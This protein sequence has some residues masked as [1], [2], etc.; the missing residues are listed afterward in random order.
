MRVIAA[1][2]A[3]APIDRG[4]ILPETDI[5]GLHAAIVGTLFGMDRTQVELARSLGCSTDTVSRHRVPIT[6]WIR[7][8]RARG[9]LEAVEGIESRAFSELES[10]LRE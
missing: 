3:R 7:G 5:E 9:E 1:E 4:N 10:R 6:R 2:A 8:A